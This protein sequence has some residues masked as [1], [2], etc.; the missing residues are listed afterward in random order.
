MRRWGILLMVLVCVSSPAFGS[1]VGDTITEDYYFP[2][3]T[4]LLTSTSVVAPGTSNFFGSLNLN[5]LDGTITADN[6]TY[7]WTASSGFN[8]IVFTDTTKVPNF[9]SFNLVSITGYPPTVDPIL[10]F[11]AD[12]L[13][14]NFNAA[15]SDNL[16]TNPGAFYT[17]SYSYGTPV[18][19]PPS[20]LLLG[21]GLLGL[22]GWRR[23]RK[24]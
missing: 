5:F 17:F 13:I 23:F 1:I 9:N 4:T 15:S 8:G 11:N 20:M 7:G 19:L 3:I 2:T 22:V 18:P 24:S 6:P 12:Q 16:G 14:V 21:S 10:S